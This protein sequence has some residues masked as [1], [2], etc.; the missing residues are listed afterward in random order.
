MKIIPALLLLLLAGCNLGHGQFRPDVS[1][2]WQVE[3]C[4]PFSDLKRSPKLAIHQ[5]VCVNGNRNSLSF[6]V[7]EFKDDGTYWD[8]EQRDNVLKEIERISHGQIRGKETPGI[9]EGSKWGRSYPARPIHTRMAPQ[10][11]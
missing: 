10:R 1:F 9:V 7:I 11:Q 5:D 3:D 6:A 2:N 4:T 8:P